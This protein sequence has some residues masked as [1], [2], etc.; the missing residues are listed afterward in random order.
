MGWT[1]VPG[2]PRQTIQDFKDVEQYPLT[3]TS[4]VKKKKKQT[5]QPLHLTDV[6]K[7]S[8]LRI[9]FWCHSFIFSWK[10]QFN[11]K[12]MTVLM[13]IENNTMYGLKRVIAIKEGESNLSPR[14]LSNF[15]SAVKC[16]N[17]ECSL[18]IYFENLAP[19]LINLME[20]LL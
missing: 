2:N 18:F 6:V 16:N 11:S 19:A 5:D 12:M 20:L 15:Q 7:G 10:R 4:T 8:Q 1:N 14:S 17:P 13:E 9:F 3:H